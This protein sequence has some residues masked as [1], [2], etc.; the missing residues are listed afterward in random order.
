MFWSL[1]ATTVMVEVSVA[2]SDAIEIQKDALVTV[3]PFTVDWR[4]R[5]EFGST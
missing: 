2:A 3:L 1:R 4:A 5:M